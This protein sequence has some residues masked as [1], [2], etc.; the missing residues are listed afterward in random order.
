MKVHCN[1]R[2]AI[3]STETEGGRKLRHVEEYYVK[4]CVNEGSITINW[5]KSKDQRAD[6]FTKPLALGT[7]KY[8]V[9]LVFNTFSSVTG[10]KRNAS[11]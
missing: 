8:L 1:N 10:D 11:Y 7:H 5:I 2:A 6:I 3:I 9:N 4:E